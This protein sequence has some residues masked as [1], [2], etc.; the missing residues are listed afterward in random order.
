MTSN[1]SWLEPKVLVPS[2]VAV[3]AVAL[4]ILVLVF[5]G[6]SGDS[7][8]SASSVSSTSSSVV[9]SVTDPVSGASG[10][11]EPGAVP[12]SVPS[13][14]YTTP[15]M[16]VQVDAPPVDGAVDG[17][18]ITVHGSPEPG[19]KLYG[20]EARLCRGDVAVVDDGMFTPTLGGV[21]IAKPLSEISDSKVAVVGTEPFEGL[22][23]TFRVG[24]GSTTFKTQY[25][26]PST[27]TCGPS[28]PCQIVL[29]LQYPKGFGFKGIPVT[30]R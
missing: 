21:C 14:P 3:V 9:D 13:G 11:V 25:D 28:S 19:S 23:I 2:G 1:S 6:N 24:V 22:D 18:A 10:P 7:A 26:G 12:A 15:T 8:G 27:I 5:G 29:K 30:Y 4:L 17:E 20:V 16:P